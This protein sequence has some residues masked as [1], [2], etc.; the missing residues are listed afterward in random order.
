M[1]YVLTGALAIALGVVALPAGQGPQPT[2]RIVSPKDGTYQSSDVTISAVVDPPG[3]T[4]ARMSFFVDGRLRCTVERPPFQCNWNVG[5]DVKEHSFRVVATLSSG[6]RRPPQTVRSKGPASEFTDNADVDIIQLTV[7][8]LDGSRFVRDLPQTAFRVYE[9]DVRQPINYFR[10]E[11]TALELVTAIDVSQS[12]TGAIDQMKENVKHFVSALRPADHIWLTPFNDNWFV[13][14]TPSAERAALLKAID[15]LSA[16]GST[17]LYD[18]LIRSLD[19]LGRQTGRRAVVI[20]TD[21][22]DT[23]SRVSFEAAERQAGTSDAV[24]YMI[25]Q[26]RVIDDRSL[27]ALCERL[28]QKSGGRAFFPRTIDDVRP[29][30]DQIVDELSNQYLI[31]YVPPSQKRDSTWHHIRVEVTGGQYQVRARQGYS[32]KTTG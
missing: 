15:H 30:F 1:R 16:W 10:A 5:R 4:V 12:M 25:G 13:L 23:S 6:R 28:A 14:E 27:K 7:T 32:F 20:F 21:G 18:V 3:E 11:N 26:G 8:V 29:V 31:T 24:L 22:D 9:D 17:S 19:L 2:L